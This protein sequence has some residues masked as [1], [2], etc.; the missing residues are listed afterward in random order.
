M[1]VDVQCGGDVGM[2]ADAL[3]GLEIDPRFGQR[4]NIGMPEDV[5]RCT[6]QIDL[7]LD[8]LIQ[9]PE[10]HVGDGGFTAEHETRF[11]KGL[12]VF[13]QPVVHGN[14]PL[15]AVGLG[16]A[17]LG[18]IVGVGDVAFNV[19]QLLLK[20]DILPLEPQHFAPAHAGE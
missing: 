15:A 12:Q 17:D 14:Y 9:P 8:A 7:S 6:V 11:L 19:D 5:G 20:V 16:G 18:L 2:A 3:N 10:D 4:G 1:R 13:D